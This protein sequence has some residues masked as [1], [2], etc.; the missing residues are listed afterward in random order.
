M[1]KE[2]VV[3]KIVTDGAGAPLVPVRFV[4]GPKGTETRDCTASLEWDKTVDCP[5]C[6]AVKLFKESDY[7]HSSAYPSTSILKDMS[8]EISSLRA[9]D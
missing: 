4:C 6:L 8:P 2:D 5:R 3:H 9:T 7:R 1:K